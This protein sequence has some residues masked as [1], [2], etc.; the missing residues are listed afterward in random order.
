MFKSEV[1]E[2]PEAPVFKANK[3]KY[4]EI[5]LNDDKEKR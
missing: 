1:E 5:L 4:K 2:I 3:I